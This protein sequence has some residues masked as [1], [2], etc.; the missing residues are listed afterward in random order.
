MYKPYGLTIHMTYMDPQP[1]STMAMTAH[2][3]PQRRRATYAAKGEY[4]DDCDGVT[5]GTNG[6]GNDGRRRHNEWRR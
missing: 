4:D 6:S 2:K 5:D 3:Q 1:H